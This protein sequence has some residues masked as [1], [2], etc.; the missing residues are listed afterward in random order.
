[1]ADINH[2]LNIAAP[3]DAVFNG[4]SQPAGLDEWWTETCRGTP[5]VGSEYEL[6]FGPGYQWKAEV[7]AFEP[8]REFELTIT[9]AMDDWVGTKV[10][11]IVTPEGRG[12]R[13]E[14]RHTGW[15]EASDHCRHSSFCWALYLRILRRFLEQGK[16][17][18]YADRYTD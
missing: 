6:G 15:S 4:I 7:T 1:V 2:D 10:G 13:L 18:A 14:F 5:I 9:E 12:T 16:R 11:F 17:V 8:D 3:V